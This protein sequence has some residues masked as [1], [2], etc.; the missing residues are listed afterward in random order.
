MVS[1]MHRTLVYG[2]IFM[3][4]GN[5]KSPRG[6]VCCEKTVW[7]ICMSRK[8]SS[9]QKLKLYTNL[10]SHDIFVKKLSSLAILKKNL[11]LTSNICTDNNICI[12]FEYGVNAYGVDKFR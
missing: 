12:H 1:D 7:Q 4:P 6:K 10:R 8:M 11:A 5:K 9:R 3:Y 2:G